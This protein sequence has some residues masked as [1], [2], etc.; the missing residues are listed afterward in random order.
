MTS[1]YMP[2]SMPEKGQPDFDQILGA[3]SEALKE[4]PRL[5]EMSA[6]EVA[7]Q[8]VLGGH[9]EGEPSPREQLIGGPLL[10]VGTH[11]Y[12]TPQNDV[13]VPERLGR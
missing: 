6:E 12:S 3:L 9:L 7:R 13:T 8:L 1:G 10:I 5:R 2:E 11:L 4:N